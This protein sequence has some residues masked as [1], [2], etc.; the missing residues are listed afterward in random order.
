MVEP[1]RVTTVVLALLFM[2]GLL[3]SVGC[4]KY[5][6]PDDLQR[7]EEARKAAIAAEKTLDDTKAERADV[8]R[9][10]ADKEAELKAVQVE[11]DYVK[12]N[13]ESAVPEPVI[14]EP[15]EETVE[16]PAEEPTG[17]E[18]EEGTDE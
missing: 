10:L 13:I 16:P 4:T 7:L 15:A 6:S 11:F 18:N 17:G 9:E 5:A 1:R 3:M 12:A 2:A 8:E 14:E